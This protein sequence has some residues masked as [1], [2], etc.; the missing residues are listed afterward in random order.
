[1]HL[2]N[3]TASSALNAMALVTLEDI[4]K[5]RVPD[6]TD[7]NA[8]KLCK[9]IGELCSL[10]VTCLSALPPQPRSQG[11]SS[12]RLLSSLALG[13]GKKRDPGHEIALAPSPQ[14]CNFLIT[15]CIS[16]ALSFGVIV[17]GG[18]FLVKYVGTMVLQVR[19]CFFVL[20]L[21]VKID[22]YVMLGKYWS[23]Y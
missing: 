20:F 12:S 9:I 23:K 3:S 19:T 18:A 13:G 7:A 8:A 21:L 11:L 5:K 14:R 6:I 17:I 15:F 22:K 16:L 1:M 4:V 2:F 10:W